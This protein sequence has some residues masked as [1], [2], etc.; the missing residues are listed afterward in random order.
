[1]A[2]NKATNYFSH[3]SN[4]RNDEKLL[5]LRMRHGAA[6]YGVYFMIIERLREETD[7]TSV[8]DYNIIAFDLRVDAALIKSV[9]E[10]FG[11]FAFTENGKRFYSESFLKRMEVKD[12]MSDARRKAALKRWKSEG[13]KCTDNA[14]AM[15]MQCKSNASAMQMQCKSNA[16]AMQVQCN[17]VK[18][19]KEKESKE[20][21]STTR[22]REDGEVLEKSE[23]LQD[24]NAQYL[25]HLLRAENK[26]NID[27]VL[28]NLGLKPSD[29]QRLHKLADEVIAEWKATD[30][31]HEDYNDFARHLISTLRIKLQTHAQNETRTNN[32]RPTHKLTAQPEDY[33]GTF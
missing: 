15:Q 33:T 8:K 20:S 4:A 3:D 22:A 9:V 27:V 1:M 29:T 6:G 25:T 2:T 10:D 12:E 13:E 19:S 17:K 21:L 32:R 11:L 16:S 28:L 5:S 18:E 14:N 23:N 31:H 26:A 7:Y 24:K 30:T